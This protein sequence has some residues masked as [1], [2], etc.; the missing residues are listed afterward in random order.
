MLLCFRFDSLDVPATFFVSTH[1]HFS[2]FPE[3]REVISI[4][5][6]QAGV[7]V[8]NAC[9][10]LFCLEEQ[11]VVRSRKAL[12]SMLSA[13]ATLVLYALALVPA[14]TL[15]ASASAS[16][17]S[18]SLLDASSCTL[19]LIFASAWTFAGCVFAATSPPPAQRNPRPLSA[20]NL[21]LRRIR[22]AMWLRRI[23]RRRARSH[24]ARGSQ[25]R[26]A[27]ALRQLL[28]IAGV[29][30][31]P[32]PKGGA[33][34]QA[35]FQALVDM[36]QML[37]R[38]QGLIAPIAGGMLSTTPDGASASK[39]PAAASTAASAATR[40]DEQAPR[41]TSARS[42]PCSAVRS[43]PDKG[44]TLCADF[45]LGKCSREA[46]RFKHAPLCPNDASCTDADCA[47]FHRVGGR[48]RSASARS[49]GS[50]STGGQH[51]QE[52]VVRAGWDGRCPPAAQ[53][54]QVPRTDRP[55]PGASRRGQTG[56]LC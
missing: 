21:R 13:V 43:G 32:G 33:V 49:R 12:G 46:C 40:K 25:R 6:G 23:G 48:R 38:Q 39:A 41:S 5:I 29:E 47:L 53:A 20:R 7:Q 28:V 3:M 22:S 10:E 27:S 4:H 26:L 1:T 45:A 24:P 56:C 36:V 52:G 17:S 19:V 9:W 42:R 51:A 37:M 16:A 30:P 44:K 14:L 15:D 31:N 34:T 55:A 11:S 18:T 2:K 50:A 8:G 35:Q 54:A